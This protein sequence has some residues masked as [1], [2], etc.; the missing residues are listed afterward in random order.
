MVGSLA[1]SPDSSSIATGDYNDDDSVRIWDTSTGR[2]IQVFPGVP[3]TPGNPVNTVA[4]SPDG[5]FIA[6]GYDGD[7]V[8]IWRFATGEQV[9]TY[10]GHHKSIISVQWSHN[11]RYI[12]SASFDKTIQVWTTS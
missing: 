9:L 11:G 1:W 7:Q 5:K 8:K 6:A 4:W 12:A 3:D 2:N 10:T